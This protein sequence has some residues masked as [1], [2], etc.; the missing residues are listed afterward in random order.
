MTPENSKED[1]GVLFNFVPQEEQ[2]AKDCR[3][4]RNEIK[5]QELLRL[6]NDQNG[7]GKWYGVHG[8]LGYHRRSTAFDCQREI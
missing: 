4:G 2:R 7:H 6:V 8:V 5:M 1:A 3:Y